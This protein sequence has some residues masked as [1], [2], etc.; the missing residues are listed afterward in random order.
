MAE[1]AIKAAAADAEVIIREACT[2]DTKL[3][4][5]IAME[6]TEI[7]PD[8]Y[9]LIGQTSG[10][11]DLP[12]PS[13][14]PDAAA[15]FGKNAEPWLRGEPSPLIRPGKV[16]RVEGKVTRN[17][18][19]VD[20]HTKVFAVGDTIKTAGDGRVMFKAGAGV[21]AGIPPGSEVVLLEMTSK[22]GKGILQESRT[23]LEAKKGDA[24][25]SV[26]KEVEGK[27]VAE[28]KTPKGT[29]KA[30]GKLEAKK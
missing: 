12:A 11:T 2:A 13:G 19:P 21:I 6:L 20:N 16:L 17:G 25:L 9:S 1:D 24:Y 14:L 4:R 10:I 5:L 22:W 23:L 26:A 15:A 8:L 27:A 18:E 7:R 3:T 30:G 29:A 28:V